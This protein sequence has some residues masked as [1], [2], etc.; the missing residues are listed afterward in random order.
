MVHDKSDYIPIT[1][2]KFKFNGD[3]LLVEELGVGILLDMGSISRS[4]GLYTL[5]KRN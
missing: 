5:Q 1:C 2:L 4:L 3:D